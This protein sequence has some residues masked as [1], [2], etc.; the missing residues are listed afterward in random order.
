MS[1]LRARLDRLEG[2]GAKGPAGPVV[3]ISEANLD[4]MSFAALHELFMDL[5]SGWT[6]V[7]LIDEDTGPTW[8]EHLAAAGLVAEAKGGKPSPAVV[9]AYRDWTDDREARRQARLATRS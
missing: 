3:T 5:I 8:E 6:D 7:R 9:Q 4:G 2:S 1:S